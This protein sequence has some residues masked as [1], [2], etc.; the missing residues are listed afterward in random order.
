[1]GE[2]YPPILKEFMALLNYK[3]LIN[4]NGNDVIDITQKIKDT[5]SNNANE[6]ALLSVSA[7]LSN[8]SIGIM[9]YDAGIVHDVLEFINKIIPKNENYAHNKQWHDNLADE[10]LKS[11]IIGNSVSIPFVKGEFELDRFQKILLFDFNSQPR[12]V[13]VIIQMIY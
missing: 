8:V 1:M 3:I 12:A 4:S 5:V 11:L 9:E 13:S 6:S 10:F 7:P 2:N